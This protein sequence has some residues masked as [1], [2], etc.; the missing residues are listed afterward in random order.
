MKIIPRYNIFTA[1]DVNFFIRLE[2]SFSRGNAGSSHKIHTY[3]SE[4]HTEDFMQGVESFPPA[5]CAFS[6]LS[7]SVL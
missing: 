6:F 4:A 5:S 7:A 2:Q 1:R 3:G